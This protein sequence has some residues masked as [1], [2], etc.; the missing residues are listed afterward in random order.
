M[1]KI[2]SRPPA[3]N[4]KR[5]LSRLQ[6]DDSTPVVT[7][8]ARNLTLSNFF[9]QIVSFRVEFRPFRSEGALCGFPRDFVFNFSYNNISAYYRYENRNYI[10]NKSSSYQHD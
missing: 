8:A 4:K 10:T 7:L 5:P 3:P 1:T 6:R 2:N 9:A